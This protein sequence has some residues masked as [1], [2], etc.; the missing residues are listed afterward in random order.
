MKKLTILLCLT[1]IIL[2]QAIPALAKTTVDDVARELIAPC[3][4]TQ[5][6][7]DHPSEIAEQ[8]KA[9]IKKMLDKG[10]T[11][12]QILDYYVDQYGERILASPPKSGFGLTAYLTPLAF[13]IL[14]TVLIALMI[15]RLAVKEKPAEQPL[16]PKQEDSESKEVSEEIDR[17]D[18][19]LNNF[20]KF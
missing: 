14:A 19:E 8:M 13:L 7:A 2:L 18:K 1:T 3:C 10:M 20:D 11:K 15:K 6:L 9:D 17:L 16:A 12:Q 4:Y 5:T